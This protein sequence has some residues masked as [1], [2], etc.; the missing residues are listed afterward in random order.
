MAASGDDSTVHQGLGGC[1]A[2]TAL[3]FTGTVILGT[4]LIDDL[5]GEDRDPDA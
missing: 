2:G 3:G 1:N 4:A 5:F